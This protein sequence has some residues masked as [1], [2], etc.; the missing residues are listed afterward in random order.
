MF[1]I[2]IIIHFFC[3]YKTCTVLLP[4]LSSRTVTK[5]IPINSKPIET[6][7]VEIENS[8]VYPSWLST[9]DT[10]C[11]AD[12][13]TECLVDS[14]SADSALQTLV[15]TL[16]FWLSVAESALLT[17]ICWLPYWL[18]SADF[19]TDSDPPTAYWLQTIVSVILTLHYILCPTDS[20]HHG[21]MQRL[22]L[23]LTGRRRCTCR[24]AATS[25]SPAPSRS[26]S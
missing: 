11:P 12:C 16:I 25:P 26:S 21:F 5:Q 4:F 15:L 19:P 6:L 14:P 13:H 23:W 17:L 24:L 9:I 22:G 10:I 18:W 7:E 1:W 3:F 8:R 20:A 2:K